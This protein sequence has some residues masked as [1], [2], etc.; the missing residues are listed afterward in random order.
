MPNWFTKTR[1]QYYYTTY[2]ILAFIAAIAIITYLLPKTAKFKYE[3]AKGVPWMHETLIAPFDFPIYK[4]QEELKHEKD[5]LLS[6]FRPYFVL[7]TAIETQQIASFSKNFDSITD[8]IK[9]KYP[10]LFKQKFNKKYYYEDIKED[11]IY[12]LKQVYYK[13][14]IELP[15]QYIDVPHT[16]ELNLIKGK[17]AEPSGLSEFLTPKTAYKQIKINTL[18]GLGNMRQKIFNEAQSFIADLQLNKY[19]RPNITYDKERTEIEKEGLIKNISLTS[20]KVLKGQ[21]IIDTGEIVDSKTEKILNSLKIEYENRM[22]T[23]SGMYIILLAQTL[24]IT[25]F[26]IIIFLFFYY[27]RK[28][29]FHN[30]LSIIFILLMVVFIISIVAGI[31]SLSKIPLF[32]I[33]FAILPIIIRIFF[34]SRLAFFLYIVTIII[35][36]FFAGNSF[37]FV[38]LQIPASM[39]A[40]FS[41][42]IMVRRSQLV[43]AA[44][45]IF[46]TYSLF[47]TV[48]SLW[49]EG[50]IRK[51]DPRFFGMF[52]I[53]SAL[54]LLAY[55]L[56]DIFERTFRFVS[57]VTLMELSDTNHPLLRMLAEKAPGTFQH[58]IQVANLAQE[59]AYRINGNPMLVR[60]GAMYHDIGKTV[61][62]IFFTE[63]QA[64]GFNPHTELDFEES[65]RIIINHVENG[66]KLARKEK[67]PEQIIDFIRTHHGTTKTKFFY[68]SY[69]NENPDANPEEGMFSYPGP[70]PFTKET[71]ILMMADS[72]EAASKSMKNY[73]DD[74]I[75][76][77]V[78]TIITTQLR[79]NQFINAPITFKE[80]TQAKDIFKQK[81]KNIYHARIQYPSLKKKRKKKAENK[82]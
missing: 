28:D 47:Y 21:R 81:L 23:S 49:Q 69:M 43:R 4:S 15:D 73:T 10:L 29:V 62:P 30:L 52:A 27:F 59:V 5:S 1:K 80:I 39:V 41:L 31:H 37:L 2:R 68:N 72:I 75:D 51:I 18:N 44:F 26:F 22:G 67:L 32:I 13:G 65:A 20:G 74:E 61:S 36:A 46:I 78:E 66:V 57:D 71:A 12:S 76:K 7:D 55:P 19:I 14:I 60:A 77:L 6:S 38:L 40:I 56:I 11:I 64:A 25:L 54:I 58:S 33:P 45:Y 9:D 42:F 24:L 50:D 70:T 16:F 35:S 82:G 79:E 63:N 8:K 53:N 34:D 3:Y 17:I 48:I